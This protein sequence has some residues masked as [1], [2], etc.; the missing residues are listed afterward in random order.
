MDG[1]WQKSAG[2]RDVDGRAADDDLDVRVQWAGGQ[3][4][5]EFG[6]RFLGTVHLPVTS[7]AEFTT[8]RILIDFLADVTRELKRVEFE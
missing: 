1:S 2:E 6:D 4:L 3:D 5:G 8:H 7:N